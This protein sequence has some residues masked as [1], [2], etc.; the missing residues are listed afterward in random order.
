[1]AR[2]RRGRRSLLRVAMPGITTAERNAL[3]AHWRRLG[4]MEHASIAAFRQLRRQLEHL[5]APATLL[6][7]CIAAATQEAEHARRCFELASRYAG[8]TIE[9]G[10][11]RLPRLGQPTLAT[12][13]ADSLRDGALNEGYAAWIAGA[14]AERATDPTVIETLRV[15]EQD[16][17]EHA[18]LSWHVVSWC[19][20]VGDEDVRTALMNTAAA[21]GSLAA[22]SGRGA[23]HFGHGM[24]DV[25]PIG[26][27][28]RAVAA[29]VRDRVTD[30]LGLSA[31]TP[32]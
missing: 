19:L 9:P 16:E 27:G 1:M 28:Y 4:E 15:I 23:E 3:A 29:A 10:T 5:G 17:A 12:V 26:A 14:Q 18:A 31:T 8:A 22:P 2:S 20:E 25:D 7:D 24:G 11:V 21:F 30:V 13:A 6:H 32:R